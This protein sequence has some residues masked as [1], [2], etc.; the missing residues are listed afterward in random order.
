M[1]SNLAPIPRKDH[2]WSGILP[3]EHTLSDEQR[4]KGLEHCAALRQ[5]LCEGR[6]SQSRL[7]HRLC[8]LEDLHA[9]GGWASQGGNH[10]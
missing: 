8:L 4:R 5:K 10:A 1:H 9:L 2:T 6:A 7:E 3:G